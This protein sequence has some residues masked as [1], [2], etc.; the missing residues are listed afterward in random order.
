MEE[1]RSL[2]EETATMLSERL[3]SE[4][5]DQLRTSGDEIDGLLWHVAIAVGRRS[6]ELLL[7]RWSAFFAE[8]TDARVATPKLTTF[9]TVLGVVAVRLLR[10]RERGSREQHSP[11]E[12]VFGVCSRGR[13]PRVQRALV[14]FGSE[15]SFAHASERFREH[16]GFDVGRT[17]ILRLT[18]SHGVRAEEFVRSKLER[19]TERVPGHDGADV[20]F[21]QLDGSMVPT[22]ESTTAGR[23][24]KTGRNPKDV[25]RPRQWRE[26]RVGLAFEDGVVD[27]TYV[28]GITSYDD[29]VEQ[30]YGA[31]ANQNM[32]METQVVATADGG[33]GL[34]AAVQRRFDDCRF[35]LDHPHLV[36]H[37]WNVAREQHA[38]AAEDWV[39]GTL[40]RLWNGEAAAVHEEL[41]LELGAIRRAKRRVPDPAPELRKFL[42]YLETHI[43]AVAYQAFEDAGWVIGSGRCESAHRQ[44]PQARLKI[45]GATWTVNTANQVIALR[46]LRANGWW[47]EFWGQTYGPKSAA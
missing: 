27:P 30:L 12:T 19:A 3:W 20:V 4:F 26:V 21:V 41:K 13:S 17:N 31:A 40:D 1:Y 28:A 38:D 24:G 35:I 32:G 44:I 10:L 9:A 36:S 15:E 29:I 37:L 22:A 14:D 8:T 23:L 18:Q 43:D 16:Y 6:L 39:D 11:M 34:R 5:R 7:E 42:D 25:L 2:I 45:P 47:D 33:N 46:V